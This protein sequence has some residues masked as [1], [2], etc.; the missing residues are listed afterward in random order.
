MSIVMKHFPDDKG[1]RTKRPQD[2][3]GVQEGIKPEHTTFDHLH[4]HAIGSR[5]NKRVL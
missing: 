2:S 3:G 5:L 1:T 4:D